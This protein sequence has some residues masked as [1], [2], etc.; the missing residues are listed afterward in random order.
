ME[1]KSDKNNFSKFGKKKK[2]KKN[3]GVF[4][5]INIEKKN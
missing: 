2:K 4:M 3:L 5:K 1:N